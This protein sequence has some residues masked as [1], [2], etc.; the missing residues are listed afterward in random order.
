MTASSAPRHWAL[1]ASKNTVDSPSK[2]SAS[3]TEPALMK[4]DY[5][6]RC[7]R[8]NANQSPFAQNCSVSGSE[9]P[10]PFI[11]SG[12][13]VELVVGAVLEMTLGRKVVVD[14]GVDCCEL[15]QG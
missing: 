13:A 11:E 1:D 10:A 15:L 6:L 4:P 12:G 2:A 3:A 8:T 7:F 14:R 9:K 5:D